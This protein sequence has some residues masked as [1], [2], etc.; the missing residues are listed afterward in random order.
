MKFLGDSKAQY[1]D[2]ALL[3]SI[4]LLSTYDVFTWI[5]TAEE[6]AQSFEAFSLLRFLKENI[7]TTEWWLDN[8]GA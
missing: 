4:M 2:F 6:V 5:I 3:T 8:D 1:A 7:E